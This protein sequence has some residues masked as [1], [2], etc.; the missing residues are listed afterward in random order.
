MMRQAEHREVK[1]ALT[2]ALV[3][4]GVVLA[5]AAWRE[6]DAQQPAPGTIGAADRCKCCFKCECPLLGD[7][8]PCRKAK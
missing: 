4:F 5:V 1:P 7:G 6:Y 2:L 3:L 8:C